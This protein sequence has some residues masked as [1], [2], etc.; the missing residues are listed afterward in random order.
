METR[1]RDQHHHQ[2]A[3]HK[4]GPGNSEIECSDKGAALHAMT[5]IEV[6]PH[7]DYRFHSRI[8][9]QQESE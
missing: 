2:K 7:A 1:M 3:Q 9:K 8:Y 6:D 5:E 4:K